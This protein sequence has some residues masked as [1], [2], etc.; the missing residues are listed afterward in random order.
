MFIFPD[1]ILQHTLTSGINTGVLLM[2]AQIYHSAL[3][4]YSMIHVYYFLNSDYILICT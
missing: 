4:P 3:S 2:V 1:V